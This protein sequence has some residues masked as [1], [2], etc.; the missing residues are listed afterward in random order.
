LKR[1]E[2]GEAVRQNMTNCLRAVRVVHLAI[3]MLTEAQKPFDEANEDHLDMLE[4]F[5]RNI[6]PDMQRSTTELV[7]DDWGD[8]GFQGRNPGTDFRGMGSLALLQL[9]HFSA[10]RQQSAIAALHHSVHPV[11]YFPFATVGINISSFVM[12]LLRDTHL[13]AVMFDLIETKCENGCSDSEAGEAGKLTGFVHEVYCE[14]FERFVEVWVKCDPPDGVMA[15]PRVFEVVKA[16]FRLSFAPL[17]RQSKSW[18]PAH[19]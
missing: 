6:K 4:S 5:W 12:D 17:G 8:V 7:S 11:R 10:T 2:R 19:S 13:H 15:F 3:A 18:L 9:L 14:V 1:I 16:H